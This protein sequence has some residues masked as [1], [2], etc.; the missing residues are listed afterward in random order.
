[1]YDQFYRLTAEPFR[2]SPDHRFCYDHQGYA[3]A[4]AYMAYAF[5][6]AEGFVMITGRPGTGKTTLIGELIESLSD[7]SVTTANLVCT[8]LQSDDLLKMVAYSFGIEPGA[9]DKGELLQQLATLLRQ[10]QRSGR[11]ALL[12][13]DEAQ[14]LSVSAMEELRLLTNIQGNGKPLLQIFLLGQP[15]LR[16]MILT[17]AME[18]LHQRIVAA[19]HLEPLRTDET[20]T[21]IKH[22]LNKVG[23][24]GDPAF[25]QSLYPLIHKF[26]EG[27][28]RRINLICSR[29]FLHGCVE[30]KHALGVQDL[31]EV[32]QELHSEQLA[33]GSFISIT[34]FAVEDRFE[35]MPSSELSLEQAGSQD[36]DAATVSSE[37]AAPTA[38][39]EPESETEPQPQAEAEYAQEPEPIPEPEPEPEPEPIRKHKPEAVHARTGHP[40]TATTRKSAR[41]SRRGLLTFA[42]IFNLALLIAL[43]FLF[44]PSDVLPPAWLDKLQTFRVSAQAVVTDSKKSITNVTQK[45]FQTSPEQGVQILPNNSLTNGKPGVTHTPKKEEAVETPVT[46]LESLSMPEESMPVSEDHPASSTTPA[47]PHPTTT[48]YPTPEPEPLAQ[49]EWTLGQ[50]TETVQTTDLAAPEIVPS[51]PS[52]PSTD[53]ASTITSTPA[54]E[55][56]PVDHALVIVEFGFD[57]TELSVE[58]RDTLTELAT[59]LTDT[60]QTVYISGYAD[61]RGEPEY[62]LLLSHKRANAVAAHLASNGI[63]PQRL[64]VDGRGTYDDTT[65]MSTQR[66]LVAAMESPRFVQILFDR[67]PSP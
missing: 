48:P 46:V 41:T 31:K 36:K 23:W 63:D 49:D 32:I 20:E 16:E 54:S 59:S 45:L 2:L 35:E 57:S 37:A 56:T 39:P 64:T 53:S 22:R 26:S 34:D 50:D 55:P 8:Q 29:L 30:Q 4:R 62:N 21:Y 60:P 24:A 9:A 19:S 43:G 12:T 33:A 61:N 6:Q 40:S 58:A 67:E 17:P 13:V 42:L 3:K 18:Q 47:A 44:K 11:R 28:P 1:M 66:E 5:T 25:S 51:T 38:E 7:D 52:L 14:D 15:E 10:W 27:I 65:A